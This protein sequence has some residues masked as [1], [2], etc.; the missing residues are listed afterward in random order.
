MAQNICIWV[1]AYFIGS[2]PFG[3]LCARTQGIDLR[4]HGSKNI[5]ATN[6]TRILGKR[7]G[8][9]TLLGD[10][11][12]GWLAVSL[13]SWVLSDSVAVAGAGLMVFLGHLFSIFLQ[14]KGGKGVATGLGI[15]LNMMPMGTLGAMGV[16]AFTLW[17]S[18][19]V[20][21]SSIFAAIA[22]PMFGIFLKIPLPYLLLSLVIAMLIV[23]K[24]H[25]NIRRIMAKTEP[26]FKKNRN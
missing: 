17:V 5:G 10:V 11:L 6:V 18:K 26:Y 20:S 8:I 1:I 13:A 14:F 2:V 4:E 25:E 9:L 19:Y 16:F 15:H 7:A 12:K 22:L 3:V 23:F 21:L 24:H